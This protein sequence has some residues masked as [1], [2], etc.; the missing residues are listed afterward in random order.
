MAA[1]NF[2][3]DVA[4]IAASIQNRYDICGERRENPLQL[5]LDDDAR[6]CKSVVRGLENIADRSWFQRAWTWQEFYLAKI[7]IFRCGNLTM[8]SSMFIDG[9]RQVS[10]P[11][12]NG[13]R[14]MTWR[15][16]LGY[17]FWVPSDKSELDRQAWRV[18]RDLEHSITSS[19]LDHLVR[20]WNRQATD[21]RDKVYSLL[22][23]LEKS[24]LCPDYRLSRQQ[25][26]TMAARACI[27]ENKNLS[28]MVYAGSEEGDGLP[29]WAPDWRSKFM[30]DARE[31]SMGSMFTSEK[32]NASPCMRGSCTDESMLS[33]SGIAVGRIDLEEV[34]S[35]GI[36]HE[37]VAPFPKC[38]MEQ[39]VNSINLEA[40]S[41]TEVATAAAAPALLFLAN[42]VHE[43]DNRGCDC[44]LQY[45]DRSLKPYDSNIIWRPIRGK[46]KEAKAWKGRVRV[47]DWVVILD[48]GPVPFIIRPQPLC[49]SDLAGEL[50]VPASCASV[51]FR[52]VGC[53]WDFF[54]EFQLKEDQ[55]LRVNFENG[56]FRFATLSDHD[57]SVFARAAEKKAWQLLDCVPGI[58]D[59]V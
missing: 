44:M 48:G 35:P 47:G 10:K 11:V 29:S 58:F 50:E 20:R 17:S 32:A 53:F 5:S 30:E 9:I 26:Y 39:W 38:T 33:L 1:W 12:N 54:Y 2:I 8:A 40:D 34:L 14:T 51:P 41:S 37:C 55:R 13:E 18:E 42:A 3:Y 59:L 43:H 56:R 19:L 21:D 57:E 25:V 46:T 52:L 7:L 31:L 16:R 24:I 23:V 49:E 22:G 27:E 6:H 15:H 28:V 45:T 4:G 36:H